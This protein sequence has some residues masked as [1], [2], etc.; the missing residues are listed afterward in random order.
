ML[1][2]HFFQDDSYFPNRFAEVLRCAVQAPGV[3]HVQSNIYALGGQQS[4]KRSLKLCTCHPGVTFGIPY[5]LLE[6]KSRAPVDEFWGA[7]L[8]FFGRLACYF[9]G[10]ESARRNPLAPK[11]GIFHNFNM[12]P[13]AEGC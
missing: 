7:R 8:H 4:A 5:P 1:G 13:L 2:A 10:E 6:G 3:D 12:P 9:S 11:F